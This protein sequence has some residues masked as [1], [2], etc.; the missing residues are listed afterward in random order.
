MA[1]IVPRPE[2]SLA[3]KFA[4]LDK[5][6]EKINKKYNKMIMG[7]IGN[8]E[9]I[10]ESLRIKYVETPSREFNKAVGGGIPRS[11][12]TIIAGAPDSGKTSYVLET[13]AL[14]MKKNENFTAAWLESEHSLEKDYIINTFGIDPD[15]FYYISFDPGI[16]AEETLDMV[17]GI[18]GTGAI[19]L[20][21]INSLRALVPTQELE[22]DLSQSV[23][24]VQARMNSRM[25]RKFTALVAEYKTAF[26]IITHL[27][28]EIGSLSRDPM[29]IAGGHAIKHW[30]S[31]TLDFRK[32][33]VGPSD[34]ITK[35]DGIKIGVSV[36]KNHC[37][38]SVNPYVKFDMYAI[39]GE[40]I[41]QIFQ[42]LEEAMQLGFV[43]MKGAWINWIDFNG[44]IRERWQGK[45][46]FRTFMRE[47][48]EAWEEF[49]AMLSGNVKQMT[50]E[51]IQQIQKEDSQIDEI[52]EEALEK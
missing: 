52:I 45:N 31:L 43:E 24:A 12:C 11:R 20:L 21:C 40:G 42:G 2:M 39:F 10:L 5:A 37:M 49:S 19:D 46:N 15:R 38:P 22:A 33:S 8:N 29:V 51:E 30:S 32:K 4:L 35:E 34:P 44:N 25:T 17:Q 3:Q 48:P 47:N 26:V 16:G 13:I 28:T 18:I 41:D 50:D 27:T 14:N 23:V 7:R 36:R 1:S 6:S 9:A